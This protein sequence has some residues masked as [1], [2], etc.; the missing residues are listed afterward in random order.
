MMNK[1]NRVLVDS[2]NNVVVRHVG[3]NKLSERR[4]GI[5]A[6]TELNSTELDSTFESS[7]VFNYFSRLKW[8]LS[9]AHVK[10]DV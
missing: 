10:F 2:P 1:T 3:N 4:L 9:S 5:F 6:R 8:E 7:A